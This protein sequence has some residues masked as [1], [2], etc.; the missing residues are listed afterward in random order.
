MPELKKAF[1]NCFSSLGH[2]EQHSHN[3]DLMVNRADLYRIHVKPISP[4][5]PS[6]HGV[7]QTRGQGRGVGAS[8]G[9]GQ[10]ICY[11]CGDAG[12]Y[13]RDY[14]NPTQKYC[15]YCRKFDH[16]IEDCPVLIENMQ[17]KKT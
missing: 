2:D 6:G 10:L 5:S 7:F 9:R 4:A 16:V 12:H 17:E 8:R 11:N 1:C 15:M 13:A 14:P 3:F